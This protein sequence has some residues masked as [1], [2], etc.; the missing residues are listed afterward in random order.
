MTFQCSEK[1]TE[2]DTNDTT[3]CPRDDKPNTGMFAV[4]GKQLLFPVYRNV[5][6]TFALMFQPF[7]LRSALH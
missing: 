5:L 1:K 6:C 3:E 7:V 4:S 2:A